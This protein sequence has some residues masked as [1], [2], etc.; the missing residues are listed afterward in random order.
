MTA[1]VEFTF[2]VNEFAL[3]ETLDRRPEMEFEVDRVVAHDRDEVA[4]FITATR[5][6]FEGL[7]EILESDTSV[8]EV[9]L[10]AE[11]DGERFY[12]LVWNEDAAIVG[13]MVLEQG[14]TIQKATAGGGQWHLRALFPD[15]SGI[16]A[17]DTYARETHGVTFNIERI[18]GVDTLSQARYNLTDD[19]HEALVEGAKRGYYD[20][21]R[22]VTA[23]ELADEFGISHQALSE[24]IRRATK[25]LVESALLVEEDD[26][27]EW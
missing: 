27:R 25:N 5:G 23:D 21:P 9:E 2:P 22:G 14:A 4:P 12:R 16:T 13:Y 8:K 6:E 7:T 18:Y 3:S 11:A 24:R 17:T 26:G 10:L 1:I 19:Q 15:R 20:V